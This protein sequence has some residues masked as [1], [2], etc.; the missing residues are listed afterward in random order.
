MK[1]L[2]SFSFLLILLPQLNFYNWQNKY[3]STVANK[4]KAE[5]TAIHTS[6]NSDFYK[7]GKNL[8]NSQTNLL[9]QTLPPSAQIQ[10]ILGTKTNLKSTADRMISYRHQRHMW[11]TNDGAIHVLFN[12]GKNS[13]GA[14]LVL[15]SSFD[16]GKSWKWMLSIPNTNGQSTA[17]G[18]LVKKKLSLAYSSTT[19]SILFLPITYNFLAKKWVSGHAITAYQSRIF[20]ATNP[21]IVVDN[22]GYL[23]TAFVVQ[24]NFTK[25]YSIKLFNSSNQG[26]NWDNTYVSLGAIDKS[27]RKSARLVAL[28]DRIGVIYTNDDTF[29]WAYKIDR[30][31]FNTPW[32]SQSIFAYQPSSNNSLYS[33]HFNLVSDSLDNIHLT[34]HDLGKLIYLKFDGQNQNWKP[35]KILSDDVRASYTQV[36]LS[37]D[38]K[39]FIAYNRLTQVGV[40]ESSD[41]GESFKF[42]NLL[43]NPERSDFPGN[44]VNFKPPRII[45]PAIISNQLPL[46]Q[47]FQIDRGYSLV[48][49]NLPLHNP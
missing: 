13:Y 49:F 44:T 38:N 28:K 46:L 33:S 45:T 30:F 10:E 16:D 37:T 9:A 2:I 11:V 48:Y 29:Y 22:K 47:Q 23:W 20:V 31:F 6:E 19:G 3:L 5:V 15:Y 36:S 35:K 14:S 17:D 26:L 43:T 1:N 12:K 21:T 41:Y 27:A 40:L 4:Y 18:F 7:L 8:N 32:R 24:Q 42:I 39:L 34:T 25:N